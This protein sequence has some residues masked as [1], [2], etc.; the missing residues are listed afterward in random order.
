MV[1][2]VCDSERVLGRILLLGLL[3]GGAAI[4]CSAP[5][6]REAVELARDLSDRLMLLFLRTTGGFA[7]DVSEQVQREERERRLRWR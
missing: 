6:R 2:A 4:F 5:V 3:V 1:R 7:S